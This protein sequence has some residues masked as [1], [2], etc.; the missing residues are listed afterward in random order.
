MTP[1]KQ[2]MKNLRLGLLWLV[3]RK[4]DMAAASDSYFE[5][6]G[7]RPKLA[8]VQ[9]ETIRDIFGGATHS[10]D[11]RLNPDREIPKGHVWLP[12]REEN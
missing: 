2:G 10:F 9:R 1:V 11:V 8:Y 3:E 5:R 12:V 4:T 7:S 6:F